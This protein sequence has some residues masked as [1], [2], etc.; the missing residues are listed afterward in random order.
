VGGRVCVGE[1]AYTVRGCRVMW[2]TAWDGTMRV[3]EYAGLKGCHGRLW[4]AHSGCVGA[5]V[6]L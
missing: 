3:N 6:V 2:Y 4:P 1:Y 5:R